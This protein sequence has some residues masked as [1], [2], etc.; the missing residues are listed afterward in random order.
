MIVFTDAEIQSGV[1]AE[2]I[3]GLEARFALEVSK[4]PTLVFECE[5]TLAAMRL[6]RRAEK[7]NRNAMCAWLMRLAIENSEKIDKT[8][9]DLLSEIKGRHA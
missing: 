3:K 7:F 9:D 4:P 8:I 1:A 5:P 2:T 6:R